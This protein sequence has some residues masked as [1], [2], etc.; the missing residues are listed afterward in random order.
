MRVPTALAAILRKKDATVLTPGD[1]F[2][3][4]A[5]SDWFISDL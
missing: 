4:S 5:M 3:A 1:P 2:A